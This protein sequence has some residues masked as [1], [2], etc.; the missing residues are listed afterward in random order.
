[1]VLNTEIKCD[2][3]TFIPS[4]DVIWRLMTSLVPQRNS[5]IKDAV[6][7]ELEA[8]LQDFIDNRV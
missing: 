5:Q 7:G 1:M 6:N 4:D 2:L 8:V 3:N